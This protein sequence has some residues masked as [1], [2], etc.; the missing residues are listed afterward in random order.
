M[1]LTSS[2]KRLN[3]SSLPLQVWT[4][5]KN[6]KLPAGCWEALRAA[7]KLS[8][9]R[10]RPGPCKHFPWW[11]EN[12]SALVHLAR[13]RRGYIRSTQTSLADTGKILVQFGQYSP[14]TDILPGPFQERKEIE[15][16]ATRIAG[17]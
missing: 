4:T 8:G 5:R 2:Q 15:T 1:I 11:N 13:R 7:Q 9:H 6:W 12:L 3:A 14:T 10:K 17:D 16:P